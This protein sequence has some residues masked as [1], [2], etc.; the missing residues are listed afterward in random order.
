VL[1]GRESEQRAVGSLLVAARVGRSGALVLTGEAGMGK[2]ALLVHAAAAAEADGMRVL[3]TTGTESESAVPFGG[4]LQLLRPALEHLD[5]LPPP[6]A[7]ALA[8][9]FAL[10]PASGGSRFA[11]GAATLTLLSRCAEDRPLA[12]CVD[13]A[14]LLDLPSAQALVFATRRLTAD[15][16]V[17]LAAVR[18]GHASPLLDADLPVLRLDG[19]SR[20]ATR[21]LLATTGR[22]SGDDEVA[23]LHELTGGNPLAVLEL[24]GDVGALEPPPSG[25]P[26]PVPASVARAF[27]RRADRLAPPV[28]TAVL[29]AA[30][31]GGELDVVALACSLLDVDVVVLAEAE[32]AGLLSVTADRVAFRHPLVRSAVYA[33]AAPS[34]RRA[35][36]RALAR[37]LPESE[38]DRRV[39]HL[40]EAALGPDEEVAAALA[41]VGAAAHRRGAHAVAAGAYARAADLSPEPGDRLARLV[42]AGGAA[43]RAGTLSRADDLLARAFALDPPPA[44]RARIAGL[45]GSIAAR[46]G[47]VERARDLLMVAG[48]EV[49]DTDPDTGVLLLAD[50]VLA[51]FLLADTTTACRAAALIDLLLD[52]VAT[53]RARLAGAVARGVAG[54]VAGSGRTGGIRRAL[55]S[56][57]VAGP[58]V[59]DVRLAPWLVLGPLFLRESGSGRGL[60]DAVVDGLRRRAA[61]AALPY[62]LFHVARDQAT[63]DRWDAAESTYVEGVHLSRE[64]GQIADLAA[65]LAGLAWLEA[66][67]GREERCREH[68]GEAG[69]LSAPRHIALFSCWSLSALGE[70]ELGLGRPLAALQHFHRLQSLLDRLEVADVDL[71]PVPEVVDALTRLGR[72]DEARALAADYGARAAAKGQPWALARAARVHALTCPGAEVDALVARALEHHARTLDSFELARTQLAHGMRLRRMRRRVD[73]RAPLRE[74]LATF[75][76]LGAVP[77]AEQA[78]R[79]IQAT[80]VTAHRRGAVPVEALTP[81]ELQV[82]RMLAQ[83]RTTKEAAAALF[84]SP[85]TVEYHLRHVYLK[86]GIGSRDELAGR[87]SSPA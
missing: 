67:Q 21:E 86:L 65:C 29:V 25:A 23:R 48:T 28:R 70:L 20:G 26:V 40:G 78:V 69:E 24:A 33:Q 74:S 43:W 35:A 22:H 9:A 51:C 55:L 19:L 50:A 49:A 44:V 37:A 12:L 34:E 5:V 4:L 36:H 10:G 38:D 7:E 71:S 63:T 53:E 47:S 54:V 15:P 31:G 17:V 72:E 8:A 2:S 45:Q 42:D 82:A 41:A 52:G 18:D 62:L 6:Q 87:L 16:V 68:A 13:D 1:I 30:A 57:D 46:A 66:R 85:K 81:Q 84:L 77:W 60:I 83:G 11:V 32:D 59:Q 39:W 80:G 61:V 76:R 56:V 58:L 64:A 27:A 75:D 3:R 14:H 73:A 79:E